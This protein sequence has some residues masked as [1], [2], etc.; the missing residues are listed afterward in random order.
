MPPFQKYY[1][2]PPLLFTLSNEQP[3]MDLEGMGVASPVQRIFLLCLSVCQ[4]LRTCLFEEPVKFTPPP[5][6][7]TLYDLPTLLLCVSK[8]WAMYGGCMYGGYPAPCMYMGRSV[9]SVTDGPQ[10][11]PHSA[12]RRHKVQPE[13]SGGPARIGRR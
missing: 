9:Q 6:P 7:S 2:A 11:L 3:V 12:P 1:F 10:D 5:P 8:C 13:P 4:F